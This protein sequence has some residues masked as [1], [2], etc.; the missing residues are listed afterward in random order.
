MATTGLKILVAD[1]LATEG[2]E[3]LNAS[4]FAYDE[5]IGLKEPSSPL[6]CPSTT[7]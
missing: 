7:P 5:K 4:G 3:F 6:P 2:L 1:Q